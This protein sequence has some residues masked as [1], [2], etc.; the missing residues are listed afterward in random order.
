[1]AAPR[2]T[3][4]SDEKAIKLADRSLITAAG[5][6]E[7]VAAY[8]GVGKTIVG[9][10][11]ALD[12]A[13]FMPAPCRQKLEDATRGVADHPVATR[14]A[15]QR[16]GFALV[17]LPGGELPSAATVFAVLAESMRDAG[18]VH[19][20]VIEALRDGVITKAEAETLLPKAL[21]NAEEA[22]RLFCLIKQIAEV[23]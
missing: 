11:Q 6:I 12:N 5:K 7:A 21:E 8:L 16:Q 14:A 3:L 2:V 13:R 4:T 18:A 22:M 9:E 17:R 19:T 1:M 20:L 10:W 23:G 15:A